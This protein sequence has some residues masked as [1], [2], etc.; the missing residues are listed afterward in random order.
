M[1]RWDDKHGIEQ[2]ASELSINATKQFLMVR[3]SLIFLLHIQV[4]R[5]C[6]NEV[7]TCTM[8]CDL[9]AHWFYKN[10]QFNDKGHHLL[11]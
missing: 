10:S 4:L 5:R 2:L 9:I 11:P 1:D 3:M 8:L 6:V 7:E